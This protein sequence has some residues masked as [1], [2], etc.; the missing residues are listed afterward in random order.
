MLTRFSCRVVLTLAAFLTFLFTASATTS[1]DD[2]DNIVFE[3]AIRDTAGAVI[4]GAKV[5]VIQTATGVERITTSNTEGRFRIA[6]GAPGNYKLKASANGF[7]EQESQEV[8]TTTGRAFTIDLTLAAAGVSEQITVAAA[9]PPLVDTNRTV[10]GDTITLRE[11]EELPIINR[12]PLQLVFLLGGVTEAPLST[13]ELADEGRGVFL[14]GTPEE[15]GSFSLTGAPATSNNITIDGLDNNDDR[16]A[17]ERI[18]LNVESIAEVQ[19]ITNQYAAEYGR[20][21]GGRIN[22][23]TRAGANNYHGN[24]YSY[25]GDE[26]LNANSYFRNAR[27]LGRVPQQQRREG[28]VLSGPIRKQKDFFFASYE[29]FDFPDFTQISAF[30]PVATNPLFPLPKPTQPAA[31]GSQVGFFSDEIPTSESTNLGNV[32]A[33]LNFSQAHNAAVRFD[34]LRGENGRGF[35]GGTRLPETILIEGRNSDSISV[36]DFLIIGNRFVNQARFQYSRLLPRSKASLD[37]AGVVISSP[38]VTAGSFT[39]SDSS[40]AFAREEKRTQFQDNI[41]VIVGAHLFKAGGDLQLVRSTFNDLFATGGQ[42]TFDTVDD[43]LANNPSRFVQRFD[44]ESRVSNDVVGLFVQDEWKIIPNLTFSL[45]M[46]WDNESVLD[47]RKNFSPRIAIAWDPFGGKLF[48]RFKRFAEP[49]KTVVRAGF[50]LFYNRAL[51]RT[52]DDFS[53]GTTT[54]I[55]DS[56]VSP[57]LLSSIRFPRPITDQTL[58]DRFGLTETQFLRRISSDLEIPYTLQTGLGIERQLSRGMVATVDYIFTRG[59]H[60]WRESN[61]NAPLLPSGF[62][63]FSQ[64]LQGRDFDNRPSSSGQRPISGSSADVVRFDGSAN[65]SSSP[66]AIKIENGLRVLTL[67]LNAPRSSNITAAL[68]AVR[69]LRPDPSL[70]QVELLESTGNSF[71]H[72]GV[73]SLRYSLGSRARFRAVYTL[74]KFLDE[75]TTNTAS[76]QDLFDR[77]AERAVS[78]QDQ[79]H[80]FTLSGL[81][82]VP[83]VELDLSPIISFGSSKPFNIGAGF[84]RNLNDIENDRPN[85]IKEIGRPEWRRPGSATPNDVKSALALAPIGSTGNLPRNYGA[86]P[87]TRTISLRASR[88]FA[89]R[90]RIRIRPAVDVFNVFNNTIFSFGSEF[91]DRDDADFLVPRRTQ[92]PRTVVLSLRVS[93]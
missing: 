1:A 51:L 46:R 23:R 31:A 12:D 76:P 62:H 5:V 54:T 52:I 13:A 58:I 39:G 69:S 2:L 59:A 9:S 74:S 35:P 56:N 40:P 7:N 77:R 21:S 55:V 17:R 27:G 18:S 33:D 64:Y 73:F 89:V 24:G 42:F 60:L 15:A 44:T 45:G 43:F 48:R 36:S 70:T 92:R 57:Q 11:L 66:G 37:S 25:F 81:F 20:A 82:Q 71:Y 65:I 84:D 3:G 29:R 22:I 28:G 8:V 10:V 68:N 67:G 16:S 4:P 87:G 78:L 49:G 50:G 26:S 88:T 14:R 83:Y 34:L 86:G 6:V 32:R 30:V 19:I 93:F 85:F 79:R 61:I 53:L 90:D 72:G 47:D 38:R 41:S 80:R 63:N 75:G 91:V